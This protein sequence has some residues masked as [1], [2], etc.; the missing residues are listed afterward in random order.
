[1]SA[2]CSLHNKDRTLM[3]LEEIGNGEYRC[4][5]VNPCKTSAMGGGRQAGGMGGM[6]MNRLQAALGL[7]GGNAL[8]LG[9]QQQPI[10]TSNDLRAAGHAIIHPDTTEVCY[11]HGKQRNPS[12]LYQVMT[13]NGPQWECLPEARCKVRQEDNRNISNLLIAQL[14]ANRF[15]PY[16]NNNAELI[17]QVLQATQRNQN[18]LQ[19]QTCSIHGKRRS[20]R[21]L[22][23]GPNGQWQCTA[24]DRCKDKSTD[25]S[26]LAMCNVHGKNRRL[27]FMMPDESGGMVCTPENRCQ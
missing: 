25:S 27:E 9:M 19:T 5:S 24:A 14:A 12:Q 8:G 10:K 16:G 1:M 3:N 6:G 7:L 18:T 20:M 21:S 23:S 4:K 15:S 13:A 22:E 11:A 26:M 2:R 17:A